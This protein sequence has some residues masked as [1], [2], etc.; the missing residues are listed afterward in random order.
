MKAL[1]HIVDEVNQNNIRVYYTVT[2][3]KAK[4]WS[5]D[6]HA[7]RAW[8]IRAPLSRDQVNVDVQPR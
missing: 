5:V 7:H 6:G 3:D 4:H 2:S 1:A 8:T